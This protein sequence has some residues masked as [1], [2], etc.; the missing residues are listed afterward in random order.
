MLSCS[1][2]PNGVD[3]KF[4]PNPL[5]ISGYGGEFSTTMN[6]KT[7]YDTKE[8]VYDLTITMYNPDIPI[9][10]HQEHYQLTISAFIPGFD[11]ISTLIGFTIGTIFLLIIH[12]RLK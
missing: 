7:A 3:V 10:S 11:P 1:G 8:G 2:Q 9:L 6:A 4:E 5:V 12:R